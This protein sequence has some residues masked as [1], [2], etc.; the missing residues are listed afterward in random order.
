MNCSRP[1]RRAG[2]LRNGCFIESAA[3]ARRLRREGRVVESCLLSYYVKTASG[4]KGHTVLCY[5]TPSGTHLY[6]PAEGRPQKVKSFSVRDQA[7]DLARWVMPTALTDGLAK[8]AKI[9]VPP[10]W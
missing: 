3:E 1:R 9:M 4:L 7:M 2:T 6:D 5:K 8:A 10:T